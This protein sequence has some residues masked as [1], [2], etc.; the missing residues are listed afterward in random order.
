MFSTYQVLHHLNIASLL[1]P[2]HLSYA[3]AT[4][5]K[6]AFDCLIALVIFIFVF[7]QV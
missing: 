5:R 3:A 6:G 4:D 1:L 7:T 2:T